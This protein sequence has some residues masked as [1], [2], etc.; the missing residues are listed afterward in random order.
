MDI[1]SETLLLDIR[2]VFE[3]QLGTLGDSMIASMAKQFAREQYK[4]C[5]MDM[6][7]MQTDYLRSTGVKMLI[8]A[9]IMALVAILI[10]FLA[11]RTA[12]C[13]RSVR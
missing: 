5:G 6:E 4:L 7:K 11:S 10:G 1:K 2:G 12:A 3:E 8:M 13:L 9:L